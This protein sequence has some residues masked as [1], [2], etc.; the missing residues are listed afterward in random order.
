MNP[1]KKRLIWLIGATSGIGYQ[2]A[3]DMAEQGNRVIISGR[4]Q[5]KLDELVE[6]DPEHFFPLAFDVT[7]Y[8]QV[9]AAGAEIQEEFGTLDTLFYNSGNCIYVDI[10]NF[11]HEAFEK[12]FQVNVMGLVYAVEIALPLLRQGDQPYIVGMSSSA[13]FVGL[14]RAE[15]YGASK[16][17]VQY[18][19]DSLRVGLAAEGIQVST[20]YPGFVKTPLTDLNDFSMPF[21]ISVKSASEYILKGIKKRDHNIHFPK[22]FTFFLKLLGN[23]PS[24]LK[25]KLIQQTVRT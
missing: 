21:L 6:K 20:V 24:T 1:N 19:M 23:L 4:N 13:A 22:R 17:A 11:K 25:T 15:A 5:Q 18:L 9:K 12:V 3:L 8:E 10:K 16:A 7:S 14:P 2:L